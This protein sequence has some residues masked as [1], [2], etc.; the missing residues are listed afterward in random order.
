MQEALARKL[1]LLELFTTESS[2]ASLDE[3]SLCV[4]SL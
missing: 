1:P 2:L 3:L 4:L